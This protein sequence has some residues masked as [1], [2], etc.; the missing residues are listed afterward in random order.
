MVTQFKISGCFNVVSYNK[1]YLLIGSASSKTFSLSFFSLDLRRRFYSLLCSVTT[2]SLSKKHTAAMLLLFLSRFLLYGFSVVRLIRCFP[3][4][5]FCC[6]GCL[7]AC[8]FRCLN[9]MNFIRSQPFRRGGKF[10][11]SSVSHASTNLS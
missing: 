6:S 3:P 5:G 7:F 8:G 11:V 10:L 1:W 9:G 4:E 2:G